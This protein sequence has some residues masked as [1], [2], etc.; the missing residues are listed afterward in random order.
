MRNRQKKT[1]QEVSSKVEALADFLS[2]ASWRKTG[3][4]P[5]GLKESIHNRGAIQSPLTGTFA[6]KSTYQK[7]LEDLEDIMAKQADKGNA[8]DHKLVKATEDLR[9]LSLD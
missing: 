1:G 2:P 6:N 4:P 7:D 3:S 5:T 9:C 8:F